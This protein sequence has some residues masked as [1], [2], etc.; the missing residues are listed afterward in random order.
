MALNKRLKDIQK[1]Y[2]KLGWNNADSLAKAITTAPDYM[3][4]A[5]LNQSTTDVPVANVL[6]SDMSPGY[7]F[8]FTRLAK[9]LYRIVNPY[10]NIGKTHVEVGYASP[11][12]PGLTF[13]TATVGDGFIE[14]STR[15]DY[16]GVLGDNILMNTPI[17]I[18]IW[19][20]SDLT[21]IS[22]PPFGYRYAIVNDTTCT[23]FSTGLCDWTA[24]GGLLSTAPGWSMEMAAFYPDGNAVMIDNY[25]EGSCVAVQTSYFLKT[26]GNVDPGVMT[27]TDANCNPAPDITWNLITGP[28]KNYSGVIPTSPFGTNSWRTVTLAADS[29]GLDSLNVDISDPT[30][31]ASMLQYYFQAMNNPTCTVTATD[32]GGGNWQIDVNQIYSNATSIDLEP[33]LYAAVYPLN[34]VP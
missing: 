30:G 28:L 27:L 9:G 32:I 29:I 11:Y 7:D 4:I 33:Y 16:Y 13:V 2:D 20:N 10:I 12:D 26:I 1:L 34:L 19:N 24:S 15:A 18:S 17:K 25:Y 8:V 21:V 22:T 14:I 5:F 23:A 31:L 6:Y 3:Y